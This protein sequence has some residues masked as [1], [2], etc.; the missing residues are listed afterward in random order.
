MTPAADRTSR[1]DPKGLPAEEFAAWNECMAA[2]FNPDDFHRKSSG[3]TRL[4]N[5]RRV[6]AV[7]RLLAAEKDSRTLEVG[8]GAGNIIA[9][10]PSQ[11]RTGIDLS[12]HLLEIARRN[13]GPQV[14]LCKGNAEELPFKDASFDRV[15][16]TEVIEHVQHPEHVL[17]EI[18]RVLRP[19][20]RAVISLPNDAI[21]DRAK[22]ILKGCGLY[23]LLG[24]RAKGAYQP[25]ED[26]C[27]HI[28][29]LTLRDLR[30][31]A[32]GLLHE[33]RAHFIPS[34]FC[35]VHVVVAFDKLAG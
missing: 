27:W 9:Q 30:R 3:L 16:C 35:P 6:R 34:R 32:G 4:V 25:P 7:L 17:R 20:G 21:I 8:C 19:G 14:E 28:N 29:H 15:F 11:H 2:R 13:C 26:N 33:R 24:L 18:T 31:M 22:S 23:F 5:K 10:V 12:D 1:T